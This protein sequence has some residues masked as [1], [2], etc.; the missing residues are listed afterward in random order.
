MVCGQI[1]CRYRKQV[2]QSYICNKLKFRLSSYHRKNVGKIPVPVQQM[3]ALPP[4]STKIQPKY[5]PMQVAV[6]LDHVPSDWQV[7][8]LAESPELSDHS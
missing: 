7:T 3:Q 8:V 4:S 2:R 6:R 1:L 5:L